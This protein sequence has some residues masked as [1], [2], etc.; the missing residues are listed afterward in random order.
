MTDYR[1]PR[2]RGDMLCLGGVSYLLADDA[3]M[4]GDVI[5]YKATAHGLG[6]WTDIQ[7]REFFPHG[8][9]C[10]IYRREN[11]ELVGAED[12]CPMLEN[13]RRAFLKS[14]QTEAEY[15]SSLSPGIGAKVEFYQAYGTGYT[16]RVLPK[17]VSLEALI[18]QNPN[19]FLLEEIKP[20]LLNLLDQLEKIHRGGFLHLTIQPSQIYF[21]SEKA[22]LLDYI[23]LWTKE[24]TESL[25][26]FA[27]DISYTAPEIRL[28]NWKELCPATDLYAVAALLYHLLYGQPLHREAFLT[29]EP[30]KTQGIPA[31]LMMMFRKG[32]HVLPRKRFAEV[33]E[34]RS[35]L[36]A[37][38]L[39]KDTADKYAAS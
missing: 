2:A 21:L 1:M 31:P 24:N 3:V 28:Q 29:M 6:P 11:G 36:L 9:G 20:L 27:R 17:A 35:A 33:G 8:P 13:K 12:H 25:D 32:L 10:C 23:A 5:A 15:F 16:V 18:Q 34:F 38:H 22:L 26:H 19:G 4:Q 14:Y 37:L 30:D 39:D 7:I